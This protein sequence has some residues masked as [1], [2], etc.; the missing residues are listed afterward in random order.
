MKVTLMSYTQ[1][2]ELLCAKAMRRCYSSLSMEK[3]EEELKEKGPDYI[4][5]LMNRVKEDKS[6]DIWE[7]CSFT[8]EIE[9][10]SR[11]CSHQLVRHRLISFD[12]ESQRF[13][14]SPKDYIIPPSIKGGYEELFRHHM[15]QSWTLYL[16]MVEKGKIPKQDARYVLPNAAET[17]LIMTLNGRSIMHLLYMRTSKST[18]WEIKNLANEIYNLVKPLAPNIFSEIIQC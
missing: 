1:N 13:A 18:Q 6:F 8:F 11:S 17:K 15:D 7:H 3:L 12:Q 5:Y 9:G 14:P 4:K 16:D 10:I 2:P